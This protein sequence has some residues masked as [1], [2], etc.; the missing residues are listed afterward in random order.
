[1]LALCKFIACNFTKRYLSALPMYCIFHLV[2]YEAFLKERMID[3]ASNVFC[4]DDDDYDD[5]ANKKEDCIKE[6]NGRSE[7]ERKG[8]KREE[9]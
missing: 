9:K 3:H 1:M 4:D 5:S 7:E 8:R 6:R 2:A